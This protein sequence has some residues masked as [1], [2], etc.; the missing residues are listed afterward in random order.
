MTDDSS[1][2]DEIKRLQHEVGRLRKYR[3][4]VEGQRR[5]MAAIGKVG[6]FLWFGPNISQATRNWMLARSRGNP[7]P[8]TETADL[9]AAVIKRIVRVGMVAIVLSAIPTGLL[10]WQNL[11]MQ[12]QVSE[13]R[14]QTLDLARAQR[15]EVIG[16][17]LAEIESTVGMKLDRP[18][19]ESADGA[20][21]SLARAMSEPS[22]LEDCQRDGSH[23]RALVDDIA[24]ELIPFTRFLSELYLLDLGA[25]DPLTGLPS[26]QRLQ[27][28]GVATSSDVY[29]RSFKM[30]DV[31]DVITKCRG[32]SAL[33]RFIIW[34]SKIDDT[35]VNRI[36]K[37]ATAL[38]Y[39]FD[40]ARMLIDLEYNFVL[41][42]EY[43]TATAKLTNQSSTDFSVVTVEC[44]VSDDD[45]DLEVRD[46]HLKLRANDEEDV[47]IE[48]PDLAIEDLSNIYS[49]C[50]VVAAHPR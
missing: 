19:G 39:R 17:I 18:V 1:L 37:R 9:M 41:D 20:V 27:K 43:P 35:E 46:A 5:A 10:I 15:M 12:K 45:R 25:L 40:V 48:F 16:D 34:N 26:E 38:K 24:D 30:R 21:I 33:D 23:A 28:L 42:G 4:V 29:W 49:G 11:T 8:L 50:S 47:A 22:F 7:L 14:T 3:S 32:M 44:Y 6:A 36:L 2:R 13:T 31:L